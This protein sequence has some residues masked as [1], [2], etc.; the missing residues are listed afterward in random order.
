MEKSILVSGYFWMEHGGCLALTKDRRRSSHT[1]TTCR[2]TPQRR[3]Q[4]SSPEQTCTMWASGLPGTKA[5]NDINIP[6]VRP[7]CLP[8]PSDLSLRCSQGL[9]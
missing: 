3:R 6:E 4:D 7:S 2:T 8:N 1:V 9:E 5:A